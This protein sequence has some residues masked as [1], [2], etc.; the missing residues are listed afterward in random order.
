VVEQSLARKLDHLLVVFN[1][2][3][4]PQ[5]TSFRT[6]TDTT[7]PIIHMPQSRDDTGVMEFLTVRWVVANQEQNATLKGISSI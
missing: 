3:M 1:Y 2:M 5:H 6:E 7:T 4:M